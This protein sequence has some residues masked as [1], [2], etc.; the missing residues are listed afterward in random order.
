[1]KTER[2]KEME[3]KERIA[4]DKGLDNTLKLLEEGYL[5]IKNRM[6]H[7]Q[8]NM[9]ETHIMGEK[10]ICISGEEACKIFYDEELFQRKG[11]MPKR[12]QKTLFGVNAIQGMDN[13]AHIQRKL[14]FMSLMTEAHQKKLAELF[15][16]EMKDSVN[17]WINKNEIIL[18]HEAKNI[19]CKVA[20]FW[21]GVPLKES[22]I[23][24]RADDF[25]S[26]VD[27][28]GGVG[29]RYWKGKAARNRTEEWIRGIIE[30]VRQ[31]K[32]LVEDDSALNLM[33][34]HTE[35]DGN[36][37]ELQMAAKELI[38]VIRPIVA[39]STYITFTALAMYEHPE[40][41]EELM[42]GNNNYIEMFV[43]EVRRYYP[44]TPFLGARVHKDFSWNQ[45]EFKKGMLVM[46]D[47][48]GMN[49]DSQI[50][51]YPD[52]FRP[53]RFKEQKDRTFSFIPQGGGDPKKGHRCP[54]EGIT[55]EIMK[56]SLDF[57]V[58]K[59]DFEVPEQDLSY[60]ISRIPTLPKSGFIMKNI[61]KKF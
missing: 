36:Q 54:G 38:N 46:L 12:I 20:C 57:L 33:A 32:L 11:A 43:Q 60:S 6:D 3:V 40:C 8:C 61:R 16:K 25:Y 28:L 56:A 18:S 4:Y 13:N 5:F 42:R 51:N 44:F 58:N 22:D 37:L 7:Y 14:F 53:E 2:R 55:I 52:E 39:I 19:I 24:S 15:E 49:H 47:V 35:P 59:V 9:F 26:M 41:K 45:Y 27:G 30:E 50:W 29:S 34:F 31:G 17:E 48:Y 23:E 10:V 1:M 21:T